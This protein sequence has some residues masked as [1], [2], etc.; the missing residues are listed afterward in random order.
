M[1]S[2]TAAQLTAL[3]ALPA[4]QFVPICVV[5]KSGDVR[6]A[7]LD[8]VIGSTA[9]TRINTWLSAR[10]LPTIPVGWTYRQVVLAIFKRLHANFDLDAFYVRAPEDVTGQAMAEATPKRARK[11]KR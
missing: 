7:E 5:T 2:G 8:G 11:A 6:W 3:A 10:S 1:F 9:R 4:A